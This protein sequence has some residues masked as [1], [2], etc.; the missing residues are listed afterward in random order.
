M[1]S[2]I[3]SSRSLASCNNDK[4]RIRV[5]VAASELADPRSGNEGAVITNVADRFI[6]SAFKCALSSLLICAASEVDDIPGV[7]E[8][9]FIM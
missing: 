7:G 6:Q 1:A 2:D 9:K 4:S 8:G 5:R 3:S